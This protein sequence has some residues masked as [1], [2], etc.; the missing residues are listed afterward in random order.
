MTEN[1]LHLHSRRGLFRAAGRVRLLSIQPPANP[2]AALA[3]RILS[4]T[5]RW[6]ARWDR[7]EMTLV[8]RP[9]ADPSRPAPPPVPQQ[10][11][12]QNLVAL[13]VLLQRIQ[14]TTVAPAVIQPVERFFERSQVVRRADVRLRSSILAEQ[15]VH[16]LRQQTH[17]RA[18]TTQV[19]LRRETLALVTLRRQQVQVQPVQIV[20]RQPVQ[21]APPPAAPREERPRANGASSNGHHPADQQ[22]PQATVDARRL[23]DDVI[24]E[25]DQR[26]IATRERMGR[27]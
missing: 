24:R 18:E 20:Y 9:P 8:Q 2:S 16:V 27:L 3:E 12:Q 14:Q 4:R 15:I 22:V 23:A 11:F 6:L 17:S 10:V 25:I 1:R 21:V 7:P 5:V 13:Q 26:I 19:M